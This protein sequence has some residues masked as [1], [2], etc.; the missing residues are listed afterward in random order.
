M[1]QERTLARPQTQM[2]QVH[3]DPSTGGPSPLLQQA[4]GYADVARQAR[5]N[6]QRGAD[7]EQELGR[8]RNRSGQ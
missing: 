3:G 7:A 4:A 5:A 2:V 6:C 8:R 1:T